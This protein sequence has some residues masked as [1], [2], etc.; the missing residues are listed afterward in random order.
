MTV[1]RTTA[2]KREYVLKFTRG[3]DDN[4]KICI[5][6]EEAGSVQKSTTRKMSDSRS[7]IGFQPVIHTGSYDSKYFIYLNI[8]NLRK[9]REKVPT[10]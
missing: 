10:T 7:V 2:L 9:T 5:V 8:E 4:L 1:G 3:V 6:D